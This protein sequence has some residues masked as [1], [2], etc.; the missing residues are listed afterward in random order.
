MVES[1]G[2]SGRRP[3]ARAR[4]ALA[5]LAALAS[6]PARADPP[7][8]A[9]LEDPPRP[10]LGVN[11]EPATSDTPLHLFADAV[12]QGRDFYAAGE[13]WG[14]RVAVDAAGWPVADA[15]VMLGVGASRLVSERPYRL[16]FTGVA[17]VSCSSGQ[18]RNLV[19]DARTN[20]STA[21]VLVREAADT[22]LT[23]RDA[24]RRPDH[25][26]DA[27]G[28]RRGVTAIRL[29]RPGQAEGDLFDADL[30]ARLAHFQVVRPAVGGR[31]VNSNGLGA[32]AERV[33]PA[34]PLQA[35]YEGPRFEA[36]MAWEYYALLANAAGA[37]LYLTLPLRLDDDHV[38][39][40]A[41]LLRHGSDGVEPYASPQAHP[42]FPP[43]AEGRTVYLE[44]ANE[45]WNDVFET[46]RE[47]ERLA[48]AEYAR[49]DPYHYGPSTP[50]ELGARRAARRLVEISAIFRGVFG[51]AAMGTRVRPLLAGQLVVPATFT[52]PL[53][54]LGAVY[55]EANVRGHPR[56]RLGEQVWGLAGA[57][58]LP[59][60]PRPRGVDAVFEGWRAGGAASI[61]RAVDALAAI[62]RRHGLALVAYEA[63]QH[64]LP[65][66]GGA[67]AKA[68]AQLDPRMRQALLDLYHHWYGA[69]GGLALHYSLCGGWGPWGFWGLS[70]DLAS[71][72]TPKWEALKE[73]AAGR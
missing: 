41:L 45:L 5:L 8:G 27:S 51:D 3:P 7:A 64:L 55:G 21:D 12:R 9:R 34:A 11:L 38:R 36:G 40:L 73:L 31:G 69:G 68:A 4:L 70:D 58:Y 50:R 17:E 53:D 42:V 13:R 29:L 24:W 20:V 35:G 46:T 15:V 71:E 43:L 66:S 39:K 28:Q 1:G 72:A 16:R 6:P 47:N 30:L 18:V 26:P 52:G 23:F 14:T 62:A 44:Y 67:E 33:L 61:D 59:D 60:V 63:G 49:G 37:D 65:A 25:A 10:P 56:R 57:P 32:W 48:R 2:P 54:Y 19:H 22:Y